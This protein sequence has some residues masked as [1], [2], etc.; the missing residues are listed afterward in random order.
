[1]MMPALTLTLS[2]GPKNR[3]WDPRLVGKHSLHAVVRA[4]P[5]QRPMTSGEYMRRAKRAAITHG[6]AR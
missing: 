6:P 3:R 5:M 4:R 1:M 2:P